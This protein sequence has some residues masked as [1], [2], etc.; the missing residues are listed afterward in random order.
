MLTGDGHFAVRFSIF[1]ARIEWTE[2]DDVVGAATGFWC[3]FLKVVHFSKH[4]GASHVPV[5]T[6]IR[7][8]K[9]KD[10][11]VLKG[12]I[13]LVH[14]QVF[15]TNSL[16]RCAV[17]LY[18]LTFHLVFS[19]RSCRPGRSAGRSVTTATVYRWPASRST[20]NFG[21]ASDQCWPSVGQ[22]WFCTGRTSSGYR[23]SC[24]YIIFTCIEHTNISLCCI[25]ACT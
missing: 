6:L 25:K 11:S 24:L 1:D 20:H 9:F 22:L 18:R 12:L 19:I 8:C 7:T 13:S 23:V 2:L 16:S 5:P 15:I 10:T 21:P 14:E 4:P 17:H 3:L